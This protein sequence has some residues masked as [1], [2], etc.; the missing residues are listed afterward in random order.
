MTARHA[1]VTTTLGEITLVAEDDA[2]TGL[3]FPE[4]WHLPDTSEFGP[5]RDALADPIL[6]RGAQELREFLLGARR[7]FDVRVVAR[8]DDFSERVWGMLREI[9]YGATTSYGALAER[10][11]DRH[12]AQR[13]GQVVGRNPVCV[14][15]PCHRVLGSDGSLTGYAGGLDRKRALLELEE[16]PEVAGSRLF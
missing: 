10:L 12:L 4:H 7:E 11:G 16:P 1:Q 2:I 13:V 6:A 5:L 15:V 9:P 8:G 3:Y 14:F